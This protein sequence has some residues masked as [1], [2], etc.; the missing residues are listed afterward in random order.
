MTIGGL[1]KL[2]LLDFPGRTACTVFLAGCNL[3]CPYC[4][5]PG[6][7]VP[8][9]TAESLPEGEL[10]RFLSSRIGKLDGVCVSGGEPTIYP[11]L[12]ALLSMIRELG[13]Q[14]KLDT[15]GTN[16]RM[17][18]EILRNG[19]ADYIAMDIKNSPTRYAETCGGMDVLTE[20]EDSVRLLMN[21]D[22]PY[23]FRTTICKGLHT[24]REIRAIGEW[25]RDAKRY[26]L[27]PF[28]DSGRILRKGIQP[29]SHEELYTYRQIL[30]PC[31]PNTYIRGVYN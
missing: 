17:L 19:L 31:I 2:T 7:V 29:P 21:G 22:T 26:F 14:V 24:A 30:L 1:Q 4:H 9:E 25:L 8:D 27:Q 15:N 28:E 3:C 16:P 18:Y 12:P 6:L 13:F 20:V 23:E 11:E 5:N 10:L